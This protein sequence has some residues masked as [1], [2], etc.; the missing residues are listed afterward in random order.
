MLNA[1]F[2]LI[3]GLRELKRKHAV[4]FAERGSGLARMRGFEPQKPDRLG[5]NPGGRAYRVACC[6]VPVSALAQGNARL[7]ELLEDA[8]LH[9]KVVGVVGGA[10]R[11]FVDAVYLARPVELLLNEA[12]IVGGHGKQRRGIA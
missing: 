11:A 5:G 7:A 12:G 8:P 9:L 4:F 6:W 1:R 10:K 2:G 3:H